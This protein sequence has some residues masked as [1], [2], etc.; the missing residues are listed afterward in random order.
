MGREAALAVL[1]G[2]DRG[3]PRREFAYHNLLEVTSA[4]VQLPPWGAEEEVAHSVGR[5]VVGLRGG[6]PFTGDADDPHWAR[7]R[8][9]GTKRWIVRMVSTLCRCRPGPTP[10]GE[11]AQLARESKTPTLSTRMSTGPRATVAGAALRLV[12]REVTRANVTLPRRSLDRLGDH[13]GPCQV[14]PGTMIS[15][16]S[17]RPSASRSPLQG[18]CPPRSPAPRS[19]APSPI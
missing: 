12:R 14:T 11:L 4:W 5:P 8:M 16:S 17:A 1:A 2:A 7:S 6:W 18:R 19:T 13:L 15:A 10:G 3:C 9:A